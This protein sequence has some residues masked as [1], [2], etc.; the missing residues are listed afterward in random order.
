MRGR[1]VSV[2]QNV[3][4]GVR[5]PVEDLP[6]VVFAVVNEPEGEVVSSRTIL[7]EIGG[8]DTRSGRLRIGSYLRG[9]VAVWISVSGGIGRETAPNR[10]R[11]SAPGRG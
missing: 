5:L 8:L 10:A 9:N 3:S 7:K 1:P 11:V 6:V 4:D 2:R